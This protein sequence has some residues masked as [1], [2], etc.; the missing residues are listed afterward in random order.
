MWWTNKI[1]V[2]WFLLMLR[3]SVMRNKLTSQCFLKKTKEC[4]CS[5]NFFALLKCFRLQQASESHEGLLKTQIAEPHT[6]FLFQYIWGEAKIF[7]FFPFLRPRCCISKSSV[8]AA[9]TDHTLRITELLDR[10]H[11]G[12][13]ELPKLPEAVLIKLSKGLHSLLSDVSERTGAWSS[14]FFFFFR[15]SLKE[16]RTN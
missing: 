14:N 5:H 10:I 1:P 2:S 12:E 7:F 4:F 9:Y 16:S 13:L 6:E 15:T 3:F 11:T 8:S